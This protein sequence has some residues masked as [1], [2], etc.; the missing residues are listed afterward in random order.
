[1]KSNI[2]IVVG[3][4]LVSGEKEKSSS[5]L[6]PY[7]SEM[8]DV[9]LIIPALEKA[10]T[11]RA[12]GRQEGSGKLKVC[13]AA[14]SFIK[15]HACDVG[16][17]P[18]FVGFDVELFLRFLGLECASSHVFFPPDYWINTPY[19]IDLYKYLTLDGVEDIGEAFRYFSNSF[20]GEDLE[21]YTA[22]VKGW[23]PH[24]DAEQDA[25]LAFLFGSAFWLWGN[26]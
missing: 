15:K 11:Y 17:Q 24:V 26:N 13:A 22:L 19:A 18:T 16:L 1:M 20:T 8:G 25:H 14:A 3:Y 9:H 10:I 23:T 12:E 5:V 21:K 4:S 2:E 6:S 7:S